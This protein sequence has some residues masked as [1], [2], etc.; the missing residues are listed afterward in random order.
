M[1]AQA[2]FWVDCICSAISAIRRKKD[3]SL[4]V[5]FE[6]VRRGEAEQIQFDDVLAAAADRGPLSRFDRCDHRP[7]ETSGAS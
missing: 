4:R 5:G 2:R 7:G 3:S 6:L 1:S